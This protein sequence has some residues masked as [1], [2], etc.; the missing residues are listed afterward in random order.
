MRGHWQAAIV[1]ALAGTLGGLPHTANAQGQQDRQQEQQA[2]PAQLLQDF[3]HYVR[4]DQYELAAGYAQQLLG[5]GLEPRQFTGLVEDAVR[6]ED[7]LDAVIL[8]RRPQTSPELRRA[9]DALDHLYEQGRLGRARDPEE[10]ARNIDLLT[11]TLRQRSIARD[12]LVYAGEYA[13]PQLLSAYLQNQNMALRGAARD[14]LLRMGRQAIIPLSISLSE[15]DPARQELV[16]NLLAQVDYALW[17]PFVMEVRAQT[18]VAAVN[19]AASRALARRLGDASVRGD[20]GYWFYDLAER[21]YAE[22]SE[23]TSFPGE[24]HQI[25]W[26]YNP[27][28]AGGGLIPAPIRT[29]VYHEA[30]AMRMSERSL[31]HRTE[32]NDALGLWLAANFS[33]ELDTPDGYENPAYPSS[34]P[35]AKYFANALGP[36]QSQWVLA[37]ALDTR[38][39][40][41]ARRAIESLEETAGSQ[42]LRR[43]LV[44]GVGSNVR[45]RQPL[46]EALSYPNR[47]VQY[48]AALA[49]AKSQPERAFGGSERV[50]PLLASA[51]QN[52]SRQIAV[53]LSD[54]AERAESLRQFMEARGYEV[55]AGRSLSQVQGA[56]D[57]VPGVD[58]VLMDFPPDEVRPLIGEIRADRRMGATPVLALSL[59]EGY[60][61]L[62]R[63]LGGDATVE[64]RRAG[65]DEQTL[66]AAVDDL[67]DRASGGPIGEEEALEYAMRA[68]EVMRDLAVSRNA[69]FDVADAAMPLISALGEHQGRMRFM[70]AEVL[71]RIGQQRVQQALMESALT[72]QGIERIELMNYVA[73]S[74][75]LYG[76]MLQDRQINRLMDAT[77][78]STGAEATAAAA[79]MGALNL[80]ND[81]ILP[82]IISGDEGATTA[83]R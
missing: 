45:E 46:L 34:R 3:I 60:E 8:A 49:L 5:L 71:S 75:K 50:V 19:E 68:L 12:R 38:D 13:M 24:S 70:V 30:M 36:R 27:A 79:L 83:R 59:G 2:D 40:P 65:I 1:L 77:L 35:E 78:G 82:L 21:Y 66:G 32:A 53:V 41:L 37:R 58:V 62:R 52:A 6:L 63:R 7:F 73:Q 67:I 10:I 15:L 43:S 57:D 22:Q 54:D 48:E 4:I 29:E 80:P 42:A 74:A 61:T 31:R 39:T 72:S 81:R 44:V 64:V 20:V 11:G 14:V 51:I 17:V 76:N 56:M 18:D 23:V 28:A 9:A 26:D 55:F 16:I 33:R 25:L 47:R 69:V